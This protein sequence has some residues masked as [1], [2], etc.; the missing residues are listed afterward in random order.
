MKRTLLI[1][2]LILSCLMQVLGQ[3]SEK[4]YTFVYIYHD[5]SVYPTDLCNK[6]REY[7]NTAVKSGDICILYLA[8]DAAPIIVQVNTREDN[9]G[10]FDALVDEIQNI[11]SHECQ[12]KSDIDAILNLISKNEFEGEGHRLLYNN[13]RMEFFVTPR[14]FKMKFQERLI[15]SLYC[16]LNI[17]ELSKK[18]NQSIDFFPTIRKADFFDEPKDGYFGKK[19]VNGINKDVYLMDY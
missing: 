12:P 15:S 17:P 10:D 5:N 9:R 13:V 1:I 8:N 16:A 2:A 14:F 11:P 18:S 4:N 19:N 7:Y 6:L 3:V